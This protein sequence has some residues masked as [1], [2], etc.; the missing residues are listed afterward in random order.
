M[1]MMQQ[2]FRTQRKPIEKIKVIMKLVQITYANF[3]GMAIEI[4]A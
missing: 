4:K 1:R 3:R 2:R